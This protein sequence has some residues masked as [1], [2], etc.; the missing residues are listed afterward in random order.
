MAPLGDMVD[1]AS[2]DQ[3]NVDYGYNNETRSLDFWATQDIDEDDDITDMYGGKSNLNL[4]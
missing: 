1:M 4:F 2:E 3:H